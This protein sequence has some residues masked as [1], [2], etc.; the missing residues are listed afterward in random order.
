MTCL[1]GFAA[2]TLVLAGMMFSVSD[3][4]GADD[5]MILRYRD[6]FTQRVKLERESES[7]RQIEFA[8]G[9][10]RPDRDDRRGSYIRVIAATYGAN[11]RARYGNVTDHL[12]EICNGKAECEY[13][14]DFRV[15]G[16]PAPG[17][18]KDYSA[19][20]ECGDDERGSV[21][22]RAEASGTGIV[23]RCPVR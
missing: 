9:R 20:W 15:I 4:M 2:C 19:E 5:F 6:G 21:S 22:A 10:R 23:L 11:C 16:D 1:R 3:V 13:V 12:A 14:I 7:I 8:E 17:C 18:A